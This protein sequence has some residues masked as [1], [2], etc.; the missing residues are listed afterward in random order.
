MIGIAGRPGGPF[1]TV[2]LGGQD[3]AGD[4]TRAGVTWEGLAVAVAPC[5]RIGA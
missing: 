1:R 5:E 4:F 2:S 3:G